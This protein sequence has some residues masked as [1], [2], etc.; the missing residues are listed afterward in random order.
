M[1]DCR[2]KLELMDEINQGMSDAMMIG[3]GPYFEG[4]CFTEL[5]PDDES[6][7]HVPV[8]DAVAYVEETRQGDKLVMEGANGPHGGFGIRS[9]FEVDCDMVDIEQ[10]GEGKMTCEDLPSRRRI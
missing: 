8:W 5:A 10:M 1:E 9:H 2:V 6:P 7:D 4:D 3:G